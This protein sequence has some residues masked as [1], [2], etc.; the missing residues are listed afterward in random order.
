MP[1]LQVQLQQLLDNPIFKMACLSLLVTA[2][3]NA[4]PVTELAPGVS[5]E[6]MA[7]VANNSYH[8]R[9]GFTQFYRALHGLARAKNKPKVNAE[10]G[11]LL[12]ESE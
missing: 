2:M 7:L 8:N 11:E 4:R 12:P 5:A 9:S 6:A 1:D 10:F 3:P